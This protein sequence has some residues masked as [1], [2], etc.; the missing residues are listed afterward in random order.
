M[1]QTT[2]QKTKVTRD[3]IVTDMEDNVIG[4]KCFACSTVHI[5]RDEDYSSIEFMAETIGMWQEMH[6]SHNF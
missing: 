3:G 1:N 5:L 4:Y 6:R 2:E